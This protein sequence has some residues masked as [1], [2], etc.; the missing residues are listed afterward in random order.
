MGYGQTM[1][2]KTPKIIFELLCVRTVTRSRSRGMARK[3]VIKVLDLNEIDYYAYPDAAYRLDIPIYSIEHRKRVE[4]LIKS[5]CND[6]AF[7]IAIPTG[8]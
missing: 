7:R 1:M 6:T 8:K 5:K 4:S 3:N 2:D